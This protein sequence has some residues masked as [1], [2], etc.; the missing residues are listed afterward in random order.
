LFDLHIKRIHEYK[1]QLLNLLQVIG[2]YNRIRSGI[3]EVPRTVIFAGKAAPGYLMA[4]RIIHLINS[5]A[6]VVNNDPKARELLKIVFVP[7]YGVQIAE[8][9][10]SAGDLSQQ[11]S[12]AG[13][14]A[15]GT[16]NMK[17]ALNGALSIATRDGANTEIRDAVGGGNIWMFGY[18]FE[19][20]Q[21]LRAGGYDPQAVYRS[22]AEVRQSLDM[23][24]DGFFAPQ[25]RTLFA[26]IVDSLLN[27]GDRFMVLAD[28]E[29][30]VR[31]QALVDE[32]WLTPESWTT[33]SILNVARMSPFSMDRLVHQ[34]AERVWGSKPVPASE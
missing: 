26:P 17:L 11:I 21:A 27:G 31:T 20:L 3:D 32:T 10:V 2:R 8:R 30:Y 15:S 33:K 13:T 6:D 9:L 1:R 12:M 5:V 25:D 4:K 28:Y 34:Y 7:N 24:R 22:N 16:G 18:S 29:A 23:I 14:E 19:E